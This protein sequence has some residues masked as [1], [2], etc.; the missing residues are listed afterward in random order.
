[1]Q[2]GHLERICHI[3]KENKHLEVTLETT[4]VFLSKLY[5]VWP[6]A[7]PLSFSI[8]YATHSETN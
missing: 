5:E 8:H 4:T 6:Y 2:D 1:M 3:F 7:I